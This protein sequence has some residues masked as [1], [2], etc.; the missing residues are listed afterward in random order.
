MS[1][2]L[3]SFVIQLPVPNRKVRKRWGDFFFGVGLVAAF[4]RLGCT[5]RLQTQDEWARADAPDEIDIVLKGGAT[6]APRD[7]H[8]TYFWTMSKEFLTREEIAAGDHFF[9]AGPDALE[10]IRERVG[11]ERSSLMLQAF[12]RDRMGPA[13]PGEIRDGLRFVGIARGGMRTVV[14]W[15][16]DTGTQLQLWGNGWEETPAA[17]FVKGHRVDNTALGALYRTS[18][19]VLNDHTSAMHKAGIPS[20]RIFDALACGVPVIT[21]DVGWYPDDLRPFL[22]IVHDAE[23]FRAAVDAVSAETADDCAKRLAFAAE[24]RERH[25]FDARARQFLEIAQA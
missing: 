25:S 2:I 4:Q 18:L 21:D 9:V 11:E 20:N 14:Q 1:D 5:A 17:H 23:E 19:A 7:G 8:R 16:L 12:D 15:G 10:R 22:K 6:Y 13:E 3:P 24:M